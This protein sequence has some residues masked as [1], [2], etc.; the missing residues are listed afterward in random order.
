MKKLLFLAFFIS[1]VVFMM[2]LSLFF[3]HKYPIDESLFQA[4]VNVTE[5]L[6]GFDL[7]SSAL[8][9]GSIVFGGSSS[10]SVLVDNPYSFPVRVEPFVEGTISE[11][12]IYSPMIVS[13]HNSSSFQISVFSGPNISL[14]GYTGN[15]SIRLFRV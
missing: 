1:L 15:I 13:P 14:G 7:N 11:L 9:F 3:F 8:T 6:E 2:S 12:V 5:N 10:R 4:S